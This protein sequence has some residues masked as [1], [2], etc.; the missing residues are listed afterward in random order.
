VVAAQDVRGRFS[1]PG[2][3]EPF[4]H[5]AEDGYDTIE[6]LARQPWSIGKVGM[7]GASYVGWVQ[8]WAASLHPPHLVTIIPNVSPP[9]PFHNLP[10]EGGSVLLRGAIGWADIVETNATGDISGAAMKA[11][12]DKNYAEVLKA[13]PVL[14]LDKAV[15][16]KESPYW[17]AWMAHSA[18]DPFWRRAMFSADLKNVRIPVFHQSGWFDGDGIGSKLNYLQMKG[19]GHAIQ[20]LT[21]GP[22]EHTDTA[23]RLSMERD[24]GSEAAL[25]LQSEY[26]RWFDHWLK[27]EEN[28]IELEPLVSLFAMGSNRWFRGPTYPLPETRFEKL[29]LATGGKLSFQPPAGRQPPDR[30]TYDPADLAPDDRV[31]V[32]RKDILV[33]DTPPFDKPYTLVGPLSAVLYAAT[34]ARDT[35]WFVHVMEIDE[36]GK[37][38]LLWANSSSG[39]IRARYRNSLSKSELLQPGRIYRYNIDLWHTG[40]TIAP[41]HKL[42]V[43]IS[44]AAFPLFDRNLNTGGN[45][46]TESRFVSA[47]QTIYHD[48]GH[49]SYILLP[50]IP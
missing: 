22:W 49:A 5:E 17:R 7:I 2:K 37:A 50:R 16:G 10:F 48:A 43:Q 27:G 15:F 12:S 47:Q 6:W 14:D 31:E 11:S 44:S 4:L 9:D 38:S 26:L 29:Y 21:I 46:E 25:D 18:P 23:T 30:Y 42:R 19:Y 41:G 3:W 28:G 13:L 45:N 39:H 34:S 40:V 24:F 20:K 35:D 36:E 32:T 8:W 33:Y 1:S